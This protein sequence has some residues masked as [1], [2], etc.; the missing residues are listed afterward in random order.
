[1]LGGCG[2]NKAEVS[3]ADVDAGLFGTVSVSTATVDPTP[4]IILTPTPTREPPEAAL[5]HYTVQSG[6]TLS[7]IAIFYGITTEALATFNDIGDA[8]QLLV[9]QTITVPVNY[10]RVGPAEALIPDSELVY[11]PSFVDFDVVEATS[12][13]TGFFSTYTEQVNGSFLTAAEIVQKVSEQYSV[14]PRVLLTLLELR[15]GWL[16][17]ALPSEEVQAY[18]LRYTRLN[19]HEGL[20]FQLSQAANALSGGFAGW[21]WDD[22]WLMQ[23]DNG[24]YVQYAPEINA[25][26]AGVQRALA[27]GATDYEDWLADLGSDGFPATYR[28]LFGDP[29]GYAFEPLVPSELT[30]PELILPW[31]EGEIWYFTGAPHP[32]WGSEGAWSALDFATGERNLGCQ[33]SQQWVTASAPGRVIVTDYGIVW[34]DLDDDGSLN[35]GWTLLYLHVAES[36]RVASGT[37]LQPGDRIGHPSCE[38]G[39]SNASHLHLAR[40]YNGV[41]M[42]ADHSVWP[43]VLSGWCAVEGPKAYDGLLVKEAVEKEA[44]ECWETINAILHT[45]SIH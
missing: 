41:W 36:G 14:G 18:P 40:R 37:Y 35:T 27:I 29:F 21:L 19:S 9:G 39:I 4:T 3:Q 42:P 1:M 26:T 32:G 38:G 12:I 23:L 44:C 7:G 43:F 2:T 33:I 15:G 30:A 34:Q 13:Y 11:G 28:R 8:D 31:P 16:T 10:Y 5:V 20:F 22:L 6:D 17:T 45:S 25:G 24:E